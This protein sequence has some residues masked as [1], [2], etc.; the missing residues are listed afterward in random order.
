M[1][2]KEDHKLIYLNEGEA[3]P[4]E[5]WRRWQQDKAAHDSDRFVEALKPIMLSKAKKGLWSDVGQLY[6]IGMDNLLRSESFWKV[7]VDLHIESHLTGV[8]FEELL[9]KYNL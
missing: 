6:G 2:S 3:I 8:P 5:V 4:P 7:Q 9:L 1:L